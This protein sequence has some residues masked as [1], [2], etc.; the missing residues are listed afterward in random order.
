LLSNWKADEHRLRQ[1]VAATALSQVVRLPA[2]YGALYVRAITER[3]RHVA[4]D[5]A[6]SCRQTIRALIERIV[7]QPGSARGGKSRPIQ[8]SGDVYRMLAFAGPACSPNAQKPL[9]VGQGLLR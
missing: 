1:I 9:S 4:S 8:L 7:V 6:S 3:D 5:D 2:N